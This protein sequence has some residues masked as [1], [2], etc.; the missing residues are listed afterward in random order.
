MRVRWYCAGARM[1]VSRSSGRRVEDLGLDDGES[2]G[3]MTGR[4]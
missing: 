1:C 2:A 3:V 4:R